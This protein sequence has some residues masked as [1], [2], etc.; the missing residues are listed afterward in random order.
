MGITR[1]M[2]FFFPFVST[3]ALVFRSIL[4]FQVYLFFFAF[5]AY[6]SFLFATQSP[7]TVIK[8]VLKSLKSGYVIYTIGF[9]YLV[10]I[11]LSKF[12][13]PLAGKEL[14]R[15]F[16]ILMVYVSLYSLSEIK[17]IS[18]VINNFIR[19]YLVF[20]FVV[21]VF[22]V[23]QSISG[24][25]SIITIIGSYDYNIFAMYM[26]IG[27]VFI[28]YQLLQ[29]QKFSGISLCYNL[30]LVFLSVFVL[31]SSSRRGIIVLGL[32]F[33]SIIV[34][35]IFSGK[36]KY[37]FNK[38]SVF[39]CV[40]VVL[41]AFTFF[42]VKKPEVR[43][44]LKLE[45]PQS[46]TMVSIENFFKRYSSIFNKSVK[47][48]SYFSNSSLIDGYLRRNLNAR[49]RKSDRVDKH[50]YNSLHSLA[51]FVDSKE[52]LSD[53]FPDILKLN[54]SVLDKMMLDKLPS[55]Y[56]VD[57]DFEPVFVPHYLNNCVLQDFNLAGKDTVFYFSSVN[58]QLQSEITAAMPVCDSS[59]FT[60]EFLYYHSGFIPGVDFVKNKKTKDNVKIV[61]DTAFRI[62]DLSMKRR[63]QI[64][65]MKSGYRTL[66]ILLNFENSNL[67]ISEIQW[68]R[69]R[70]S[71]EIHKSYSKIHFKNKEREDLLSKLLANE[72]Q[73][74]K[75]EINCQSLGLIHSDYV[76]SQSFSVYKNSKVVE[77]DETS[78]KFLSLNS[79]FGYIKI[80]RASCRERV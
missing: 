11:F 41:F 80:G 5:L 16:T 40:L 61:L 60:L 65:V 57:Y 66:D 64:L 2:V 70:I 31:L 73:D 68:S 69:K 38:F 10:A 43:Y 72:K 62:S 15:V 47:P 29:K 3:C 58:H 24:E 36:F 53:V 77:K 52:G 54:D 8:T 76:K 34:Y 79:G 45:F 4:P 42:V 55:W 75:R 28:S 26:L 21:I 37:V 56:N 22:V 27:M 12:E 18:F 51:F 30:Y 49:I 25:P 78:A 6:F 9:I 20:L 63:V 14:F 1:K 48:Q 7:K 67:C 13:N 39:F 74:S 17:G 32:I 35:S 23:L 50:Y 46:S 19:T 59:L 71:T 44:F 33:V